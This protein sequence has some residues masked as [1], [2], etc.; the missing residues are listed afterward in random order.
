MTN[1]DDEKAL[2]LLHKA[3]DIAQKNLIKNKQFNPFLLLLN[4]TQ[5]E[6]FFEN[7]EKN[8]DKSYELLENLAKEKI[9][10]ESIE[11]MILAVDTII[12]EKFAKDTPMGIRLHLEEKSQVENKIGARYIY[13]PYELCRVGEG[14]LFIKLHHPI[15]VGILTEYIK[16]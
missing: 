10:K 7:K 1:N 6:L 9:A 5:E 16:A 3:V 8:N 11:I 4:D 13:V 12:P 2:Q 15:P 14:E